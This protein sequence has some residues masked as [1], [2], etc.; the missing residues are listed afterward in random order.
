MPLS[1]TPQT[2]GEVA[3]L[4]CSGRIVEGT[5]TT[6]LDRQMR[7]LQVVYRYFVL[8]LHDVAFVDS[9]GLGLLVRLLSR[10][11]RVSGDLK[12]CGVAPNIQKSLNVSRLSSV[13]PSYDDVDAAVAAFERP[14][15][16]GEAPSRDAV[17]I[18]CVHGSNDVLAY[19]HELLRRAGYGLMTSTNVSDAATLLIATKPRIVVIDSQ[20]R[21]MGMSG[22]F[23][24]L[25]GDAHVVELPPTFSIEDAGDAGQRLLEE[26]ARVGT[27]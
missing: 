10:L 5:E 1:I 4:Q 3:I 20:S 24:G 8:D 9:A 2:I 6:S 21:A 7:D 18:L 16:V 12:L 11:R 17:D 27:P 25:I 23:G 26:I 13:L 19:L 15:P 14:S 22:R